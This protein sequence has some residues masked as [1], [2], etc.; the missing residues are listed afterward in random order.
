MAAATAV[1]LDGERIFGGGPVEIKAGSGRRAAVEKSAA[2]LDGVV[3]ID[4]GRRSR[5]IRQAGELRAKSRADLDSR[6]AAVSAFMD[7]KTHK[8][9]T[10]GGREFKNVRMDS[11]EAS[12]E[13]P[14]GGGVVADYEIIYT[15]LRQF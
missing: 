15:Q 12:G 1:R 3:S 13:R 7:G 10:D 6:L 9:E 2:G 4:M 5:Q 11:F 14:S 8:L